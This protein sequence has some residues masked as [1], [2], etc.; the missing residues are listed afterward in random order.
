MDVVEAVCTES[1]TTFENIICPEELLQA[2]LK[3]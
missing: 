3:K 2:P 1:K